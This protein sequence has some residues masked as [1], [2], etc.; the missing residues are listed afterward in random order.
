MKKIS[1]CF[2]GLLLFVSCNNGNSNQNVIS[3]STTKTEQDTT[4]LPATK[5]LQDA[6]EQNVD[7]NGQILNNGKVRTGN[8]KIMSGD[9]KM[10]DSSK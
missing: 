10:S 1:A 6:G 5:N 7:T 3:D 4:Q 8:D 9:L 2:I